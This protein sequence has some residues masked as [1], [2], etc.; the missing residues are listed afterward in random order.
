MSKEKQRI[1]GVIIVAVISLFILSS[2]KAVNLASETKDV[3]RIFVEPLA[4]INHSLSANERFNVNVTAYNATKLHGFRVELTFDANVLE[5][6]AVQEG[7]MLRA[8]G[9]T[10]MVQMINNTSGSIEVSV[11]LTSPEAE[12]GGNDTLLWLTFQVK[13]TGE[14]I[15]H[16]D[17]LALYDSAGS[18]LPHATYDGYFNNK[19]IFDVAMPLAL[20]CVTLVS[21]FLNQKTESKLKTTLEEKEFKT[22]DAVLL[23]IAMA[24]MVSLIVLLREMIA[25]LMIL[26]LFS[27]STLLFIFTYILSNKRKYLA[28]IPPATF[29]L[30]Y[31]FFSTTGIWQYYLSNAYG[32]IFAILITLYIGT[33]FTWKT[34]IIFTGLLTVMDIILVLVTGTM[35]EAARTV[36]GLNLPV[37]V[38][39]PIVPL[40]MDGVGKLGFS[41]LGLGDFFFAGLLAIQTLK[42]YDKKTMILSVVAM[43]ISF[44]IFEI[45]MLTYWRRP[46]PGTFMIILGWAV[47][48]ISK[49]LL[50]RQNKSKENILPK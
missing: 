32:I 45:A 35:I 34:T 36:A 3:P 11:N 17:E 48:A 18:S 9:A 33:L 6:A 14:T 28:V 39:L 23:V 24:V 2:V 8:S 16:L 26:F 49:I 50:N 15:L 44:G 10:T 19:F 12:T 31:A 13:G 40:I 20:F 25:P 46:L 7:T 37:M 1:L 43:A 41:G 42:R 47:V 30:I 38:Q 5:C 4:V 29:V 27:Y 21:T 22:W